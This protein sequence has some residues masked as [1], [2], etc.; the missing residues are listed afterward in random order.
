[1]VQSFVSTQPVL[2]P[3]LNEVFLDHLQEN[4]RMV[5]LWNGSVKQTKPYGRREQTACKAHDSAV[6]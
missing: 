6:W 4:A 1:M 2:K 3:L 5:M